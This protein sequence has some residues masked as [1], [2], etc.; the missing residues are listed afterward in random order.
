M[1]CFS[2]VESDTDS[3]LETSVI[4]PA[5]AP[6]KKLKS[7]SVQKNVKK[8]WKKNFEHFVCYLEMS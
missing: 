8:R 7:T 6:E 5:P 1:F 2:E 3:L 4:T